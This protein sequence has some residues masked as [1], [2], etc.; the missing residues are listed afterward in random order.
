VLQRIVDRGRGQHA[1]ERSHHRQR[2]FAPIAQ[3]AQDDFA[4]DLQ[5]DHK[6]EDDHQAIVHPVGERVVE[7]P[8]ADR[9][10]DVRMPEIMVGTR[11]RRVRQS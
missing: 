4:L 10:S 6:E 2:R 5:P 7:G 9:Q 3:L 8:C 1:A 11:P